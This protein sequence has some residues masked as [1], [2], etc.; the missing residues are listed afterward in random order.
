MKEAGYA[1]GKCSGPTCKV[2]MVA[3]SAPGPKEGAVIVRDTL[4]ELG[5]DVEQHYVNVDVMYTRFCG[6]PADEPNVC[7]SVGWIKDFNDPQ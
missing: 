6:V 2:T 4:A 7:P 3:S 1:S 5:F